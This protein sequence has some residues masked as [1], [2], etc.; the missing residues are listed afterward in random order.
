MA[1][2][3]HALSLLPLLAAVVV[4]AGCAPSC[5]AGEPP[6]APVVATAPPPPCD[7][8]GHGRCPIDALRLR[9]CA[10]VLNGL[11]GVKIGGGPEECC[12]LLSGIADLDAAVCLCTAV[13]ANVLGLVNLDLPIDL[14]LI[15]N[16]CSKNYPSGFTC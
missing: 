12:S 16:K 6:A 8:G 5:P 13:K 3:I 14:S 1:S 9:V 7:N 2:K 11:I 4:H 10:N 15:L